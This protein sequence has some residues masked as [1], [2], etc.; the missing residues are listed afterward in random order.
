MFASTKRA[1]T[2]LMVV[3]TLLGIVNTVAALEYYP[4][5]SQWAFQNN[6]NLNFNQGI[7]FT[8][9]P[10]RG[11]PNDQSLVGYWNMDEGQ[12]T[13]ANDSSGN[14]NNGTLTNL[15]TWTTG[16]YA[17]ALNF[18]GASYV[19][20]NNSP[21]IN[22]TGAITF[23]A[24]IK[25]NN[26]N[27]YGQIVFKEGSDAYSGVYS[28][29]VDP[30]NTLTVRLS[31]GGTIVGI[32]TGKQITLADDWYH[33]LFSYDGISQLLIFVNGTSVSYSGGK[34]SG[35][36]DSSAKPLLIGQREA[37]DIAFDGIVDDVR[38]YNRT[39]SVAEVLGLY[40][41]TDP[42]SFSNYYIFSAPVT[43]GT[44]IADVYS[45]TADN[46]NGLLVT[47][48]DFFSESRLAFQANN[49]ATLN[50]WTNLGQPVFFSGVWNPQNYTTTLTLD[51]SS[52]GEINW[53]T[54]N[55]TTY[56]DAHAGVSPSNVTVGYGQN[57]VLNFN[58]SQGYHFNVFV[59]G[60]SQGQISNYTFSNVT[61]SHTVNVTSVQFFTIDASAGLNGSISP[62]GLVTVD[63]DQS[64]KFN[65]TPETGYSVG[66]V[67]V[68][69]I[70]QSISDSYEFNNV[71]MNHTILVFFSSNSLPTQTPQP[72]NSPTPS[73]AT[74]PTETP[75]NGYSPLQI[76]LIGLGILAT[77]IILVVVAFKKKIIT[78]EVI[79]EEEQEETPQEN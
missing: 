45:S 42:T 62:S 44:M 70:L 57:Q 68:D 77:I 46:N 9:T 38:I 63:Y 74:G 41:Q 55:I 16:K 20:I 52:T 4:P 72:T 34:F 48:T 76:L 18:S 2:C 49:S 37:G 56:V 15:S 27:K 21:T 26:I 14:G 7:N 29:R 6:A 64:Q 33:L 39:L 60:V 13:I 32:T 31:Q 22:I 1:L 5:T 61:A 50:I 24:W 10:H 40:Q 73:A 59:D 12:G 36:I 19:A 43:N 53:N 28:M 17:N 78:I 30:S 54:Y 75:G 3:L 67:L 66:S 51:A 79:N 8:E 11:V 58:S 35:N 47:C 23:S 71:R 65:F 69:D 25:P